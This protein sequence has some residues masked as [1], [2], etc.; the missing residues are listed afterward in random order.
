MML[1]SPSFRRAPPPLHPLL[2]FSYI[3]SFVDSKGSHCPR[4]RPPFSFTSA[5]FP[6]R[7]F[8]VLFICALP[9]RGSSPGCAPSVPPFLPLTFFRAIPHPLFGSNLYLTLHPLSV[10]FVC[11]VFIAFDRL[12]RWVCGFVVP[13]AVLSCD[14]PPVWPRP[15]CFFFFFL[16]GLPSSICSFC[17]SSKGGL[18]LTFDFP[19]GTGFFFFGGLL[20]WPFFHKGSFPAFSLLIFISLMFACWTNY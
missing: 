13:F 1:P 4:P 10:F 3:V 9:V 12:L 19:P 18:F 8:W 11:C 15:P 2:V 6:H 20:P 17:T 7:P 5:F 16:L 14:P